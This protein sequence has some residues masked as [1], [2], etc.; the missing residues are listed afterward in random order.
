M[1]NQDKPN[2]SRSRTS[3]P[4]RASIF[5][6]LNHLLDILHKQQQSSKG[7]GINAS[8]MQCAKLHETLKIW[9]PAMTVKDVEGFIKKER[10]VRKSGHHECLRAIE[11]TL[12]NLVKADERSRVKEAEAAA[13]SEKLAE[14]AGDEEG[15]P[16]EGAETEE[17]S[18]VESDETEEQVSGS[19]DT[20]LSKRQK[21]LAAKKKGNKSHAPEQK[22]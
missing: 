2:D 18:P 14:G 8:A 21:S 5:N 20:A 3:D 16:V 9:K 19:A 12:K 13:E 22:E 15:S 10:K 17:Q 1:A 7:G 6:E 4:Q 11:M